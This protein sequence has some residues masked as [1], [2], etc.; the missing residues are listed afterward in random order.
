ML[1][2]KFNKIKKIKPTKT[3]KP[4]N[5]VP[6]KKIEQNEKFEIVKSQ[7]LN[8]IYWLTSKKAPKTIQIIRLKSIL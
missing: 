5:P 2:L 3:W 1:Y 4:W 8:S 7:T 6:K